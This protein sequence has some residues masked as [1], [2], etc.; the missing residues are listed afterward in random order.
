RLNRMGKIE[1]LVAI[2]RWRKFRVQRFGSQYRQLDTSLLEFRLP[3]IAVYHFVCA[4][5]T[6]GWIPNDRIKKVDYVQTA[7]DMLATS[8][9]RANPYNPAD[10]CQHSEHCQRHPH[11]RRRLLRDVRRMMFGRRM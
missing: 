7:A 9:S 8:E 2:W 1:S 4:K 11:R 3:A 5:E 6:G 10:C